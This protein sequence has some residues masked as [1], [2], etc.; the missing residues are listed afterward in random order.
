MSPAKQLSYTEVEDFVHKASLSGMF[1]LKA[2][3]FKVG[4]GGKKGTRLINKYINKA[5]RN[6]TNNK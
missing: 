1:Y 6:Q 5:P 3:F 2:T 4:E